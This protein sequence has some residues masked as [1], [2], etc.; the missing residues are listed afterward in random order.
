M[1]DKQKKCQC[2]DSPGSMKLTK[3]GESMDI[4]EKCGHS[5]EKRMSDRTKSILSAAVLIAGLIAFP[6]LFDRR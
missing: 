5:A 6:Y 2:K 1:L 3:D 4:C